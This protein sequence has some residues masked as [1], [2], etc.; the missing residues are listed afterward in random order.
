MGLGWAVSFCRAGWDVRLFDIDVERAQT[1]AQTCLAICD[2]LRV[3]ARERG[4]AEGS[5]PIDKA[6]SGARLVIE[7]VPEQLSL[8]QSV[9][10]DIEQVFDPQGLVLSSTSAIPATHL[11]SAMT[12]PSRF[13]VA[14]P[15]NPSYLLPLVELVPGEKTSEYALD[16]AAALLESIG[17]QVVKLRREIEGFVANRL[18]AAV[19]NEAVNLVAEGVVSPADVDKCLKDCLGLRWAFFGPF[20]TMDLNAPNGFEEYAQKFGDSYVELGKKLLVANP[21]QPKALQ[22]IANYLAERDEDF[23]TKRQRRDTLVTQLLNLK[24]QHRIG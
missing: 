5:Q 19:V 20:E 1:A 22:E 12:N 23:E 8:K 14:H 16:T 24:Q 4:A 18:Q 9:L 15:F 21:W 11:A 13:L 10:N 7:A 2:S 17:Q 6:V 3:S